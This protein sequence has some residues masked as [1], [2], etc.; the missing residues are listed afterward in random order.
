M[1]KRV[2]VPIRVRTPAV[3]ESVPPLTER[4][5]N[6]A[7]LARRSRQRRVEDP[8]KAGRPEVRR[9]VEDPAKAGRPASGPAPET[10][11]ETRNTERSACNARQESEPALQAEAEQRAGKAEES[12]EE[13]RDRALRL[14]AEIENFRKRQ[15]RLAEERILADRERL[16]REFLRVADNLERALEA[17]GSDGERLRQGVDLTYRALL[18]VLEQEGAEPIEAAGTR[19][20]PVWHEAVGTVPHEH[21]GV[22]PDTVAEVVEAG[23]RLGGRLLRPARVIVAT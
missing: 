10:G 8:A 7:R 14:Q 22:A 23:Y 17:D 12:L 19:F 2:K 4:E 13:W 15:Q 5:R 11:Y 20:D 21:A 6:A 3:R 9:R 18:L 16:L 1:D